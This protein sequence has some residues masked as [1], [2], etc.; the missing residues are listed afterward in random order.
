MIDPSK[1]GFGREDYYLR[2]VAED[3][4]AYLTGHGEAPG[5]ILGT[6]APEALGLSG[7]VTAEQFKR[8]FAGEHPDTGE[9]LGRRHRKDGVLAYD[10]VFRPTK[11]V[12][13]LYGLGDRKEA[14]A[15]LAAHHAGLRAAVEYLERFALVRRGRNG[16]DKVVASGLLAVGFDHRTSRPGDPLL[17]THVIVIN[18]AQGPDEWWTAPDGHDL[19][20]IDTLKAANAFYRNTYQTE[21]SRRLGIEWTDSDRLGDCEIVGIPEAVIRQVL[22]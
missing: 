11:S 1:L 20:D 19:L 2:Q 16:V 5:Y 12:S 10:F 7:E 9:L 8:L 21:L 18:R 14:A 3:R 17:H 4:E 22:I 6:A 13:L 15:A